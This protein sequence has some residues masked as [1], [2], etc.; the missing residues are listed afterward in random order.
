MEALHTVSTKISLLLQEQS[1][2]DLHC[3]PTYFFLVRDT[4]IK[5]FRI[6]A[7]IELKL[8]FKVLLHCFSTC[9]DINGNN[10][11]CFNLKNVEIC[12][13]KFQRV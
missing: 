10:R 12:K 8:S 13:E 4:D 11:Y 2:L 9:T 1:D 7:A 5:N 6:F 3:L